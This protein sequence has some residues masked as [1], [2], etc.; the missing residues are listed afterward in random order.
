MDESLIPLMIGYVLVSPVCGVF[1]CALL[2]D[3]KRR[4]KINFN[5][6]KSLRACVKEAMGH[7]ESYQ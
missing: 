2:D 4:E 1:Q 7:S 3:T 5:H 6:G